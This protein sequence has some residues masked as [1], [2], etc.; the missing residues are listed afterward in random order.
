MRIPALD[1]VYGT[2]ILTPLSGPYDPK[3]ALVAEF[4]EQEATGGKVIGEATQ[5]FGGAN[6]LHAQLRDIEPRRCALSRAICGERG[7]TM[8]VQ[9]TMEY[10]SPRDEALKQDFL[11]AVYDEALHKLGGVK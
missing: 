5:K 9:V 2:I 6:R 7:R 1:G 8:A 4:Q 3:T 10:A 11:N